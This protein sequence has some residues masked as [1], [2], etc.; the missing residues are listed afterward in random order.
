MKK[1]GYL[2][3][4]AMII[5]LLVSGCQKMD[6]PFESRGINK[7]DVNVLTKKPTP[8]EPNIVLFSIGGK[9]LIQDNE[10]IA[11]S[12]IN[13]P[14]D[15]TAPGGCPFY[16][17]V[18]QPDGI[19]SVSV[20][21]KYQPVDHAISGSPIVYFNGTP[22]YE[23]LEVQGDI[24]REDFTGENSTEII[25]FDWNGTVLCY[26]FDEPCYTEPYLLYDQLAGVNEGPPD[27][28]ALPDPYLLSVLVNASGSAIILNVPVWIKTN[29]APVPS[30]HVSSISNIDIVPSGRKLKPVVTVT[31]GGEQPDNV[32]VFGRWEGDVYSNTPCNEVFTNGSGEVEISG[33]EFRKNLKGALKFSVLRVKKAD[34]SYNPWLNFDGGWPNN[35][36]NVETVVQ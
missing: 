36:P 34:R 29:P 8:P 25:G 14:V 20:W 18:N 15:V 26:L 21:F 6:T 1:S 22:I 33:P 5:F 16:F 4:T 7:E 11:G 9:T 27:Y 13:D 31:I 32:Y 30:V 17:E 28:N 35:F 10:V 2:F 12:S 23:T 3:V 19:Y 24:I